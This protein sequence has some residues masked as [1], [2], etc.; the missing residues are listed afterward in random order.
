MQLLSGGVVT[1]DEV[2]QM[3][4][5]APLAEAAQ[6]AATLS[7]TTRFEDEAQVS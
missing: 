1:V 5:L 2:R 4:G 7:D 6:P 3:R